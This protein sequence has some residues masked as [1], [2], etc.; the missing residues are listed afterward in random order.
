M[1][2]TTTAAAAAAA[3]VVVKQL[4]LLL[5]HA[6]GRLLLG[7]K[8][9][10]FGMGKFNGFGGKIEPG[11]TVLQAAVREMREESGL[12]VS[13][14]SL[15]GH[16]LFTF[17][18]KSEE[19]LSVHI[20]RATRVEGS[21]DA[22]KPESDEMEPQWF[23]DTAVPYDRMWLDD[24]HWLPLLLQG[25]RFRGRF[26]FRGHEEILSHALE[27]VREGSPEEAELRALEGKVLVETQQG[28]I[29]V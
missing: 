8:T 15:V 16:V 21:L 19:A 24:R 29:G 23:P 25:R 1:A 4:T 27:E 9:R 10:G 5:L 7:M 28:A 2:S 22:G 12:V 20:F 11:E 14:P 13:D 18:Q 26:H 17:E 6:E 3:K